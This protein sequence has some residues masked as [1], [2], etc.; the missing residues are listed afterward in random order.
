MAEYSGELTDEGRVDFLELVEGLQAP[1]ELLV[2]V[3]G[4]QLPEKLLFLGR[5][6]LEES[7]HL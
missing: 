5:Q 4:H 1:L 2:V 3:L 6:R 7:V